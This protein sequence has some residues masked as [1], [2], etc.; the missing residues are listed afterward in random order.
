MLDPPSGFE[1]TE[2]SRLALSSAYDNFIIND[3]AT[4]IDTKSTVDVY[5]NLISAKITQEEIEEVTAFYE[6]ITDSRLA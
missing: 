6:S 2:G 5:L 3:L 4:L 1:F